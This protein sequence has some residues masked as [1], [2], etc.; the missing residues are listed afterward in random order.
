VKPRVLDA[1]R[2]ISYWTIEHRGPIPQ[3]KRQGIQDWLFGCDACQ[4]VCP[5]NRKRKAHVAEPL[6]PTNW[7][8]KTD[9]IFWLTLSE[10][11][12]RKQFRHTPFWRTRLAGMQRNA[13][14]VAAN[15]RNQDAT[16]AI[17]PFLDNPDP[18]LNELANWALKQLQRA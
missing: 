10:E 3:E 2:C 17:L 15:T 9:P 12:F 7:S 16:Q 1:T 4:T 11:D 8:Q 14:I 18:A 5:W 6:R 13:M